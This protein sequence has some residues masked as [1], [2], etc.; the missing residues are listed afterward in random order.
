VQHPVFGVYLALG[1]KHGHPVDR[2]LPLRWMVAPSSKERDLPKTFGF[3]D[4]FTVRAGIVIWNVAS[5]LLAVAAWYREGLNGLL[6]VLAICGPGPWA[7]QLYAFMKTMDVV[8]DDAGISRTYKGRRW[9][10]IQWSNIGDLSSR[11]RM[12]T[13]YN[14][15]KPLKVVYLHVGLVQRLPAMHLRELVFSSQ[16]A[17][18]NE[19]AEIIVQSVKGRNI[20]LQVV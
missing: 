13:P 1:V 19:F 10:T 3:P 16:M 2:K 5:M 6:L 17:G 11:T 4:A 9:L 12:L 20:A 7:L 8:V 14:G 18:F 15:G